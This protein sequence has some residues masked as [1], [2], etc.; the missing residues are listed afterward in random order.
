MYVCVSGGMHPQESLGF[1]D[2]PRA[3]LV[4]SG[5][6]S[7]A[8]EIQ[9]ANS[10]I[11][12]SEYPGTVDIKCDCQQGS[13]HFEWSKSVSAQVAWRKSSQRDIWI[14]DWWLCPCEHFNSL[15]KQGIYSWKII[16]FMNI[17]FQPKSLNVTLLIL[18]SIS[19]LTSGPIDL[20]R[21][22]WGLCRSLAIV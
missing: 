3:F 20:S 14:P 2:P 11:V 4:H 22:S 21:L 9:M 12:W 19:G 6:K 15:W 1:L 8:T 7:E 17:F 10:I 13:A 5:G 18:F 16:S